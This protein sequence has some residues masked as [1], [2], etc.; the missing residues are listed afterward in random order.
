MAPSATNHTV[1][2]ASITMTMQTLQREESS[3]FFTISLASLL[4]ALFHGT[5]WILSHWLAMHDTE[6]ETLVM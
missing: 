6:K 1:G 3:F 5:F 2:S 4:A